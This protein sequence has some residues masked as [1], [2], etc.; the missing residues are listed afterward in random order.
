MSNKLRHPFHIVDS[1]P[2]PAHTASTALG[3][4]AGLIMWFHINRVE[5]LLVS[6]TSL[7]SL[8]QQWWRDINREGNYMGIHTA[9][10]QLGLRL[11]MLLFIA[12]EALFFISFFWAYFHMVMSPRVEIGSAWP[13]IGIVPLNPLGV[14][15]LNTIILITSGLSITWSHH[16]L[17][18]GMHREAADTLLIT[19]MLG[20]YFTILQALEYKEAAF[21]ISD[22]VYGST[23]YLT[24]GFHGVHVIVGT[25]FLI[26]TLAR[27]KIG[28]FSRVRHFGFEASAWY[29][30]FVDVIW[31][32]V[33]MSIYWWGG[34]FWSNLTL[35]Y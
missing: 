4:A 10:V 28:R 34:K 24:T 29:W 8:L 26:A 14:P 3:L 18:D 22:S 35:K 20:V 25:L 16:S 23:F 15:L 33:Y 7:L 17:I 27:L 21:S 5:L 30:H 31:L 13:P 6:L 32:F 2:W 11:G 1:S 9:L 19:I 12:S